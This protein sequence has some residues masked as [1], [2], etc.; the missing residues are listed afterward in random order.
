MFAGTRREALALKARDPGWLAF[1]DGAPAGFDLA[2]S[3]A[4][5][6][7]LDVRGRTIAQKT[8][9]GTVGAPAVA[10]A[11]W[12]CARASAAGATAEV[13][14][15]AGARTVTFVAT[16]DDGR[17]EEDPARAEY[18]TARV[19]APTAIPDPVWSGPP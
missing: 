16:G 13:L 8:T 19:G 2:D 17:A 3:P 9:A 4:R 12:C 10:D 6:R 18:I 5:L 11:G 7:P 14:R 15:R 1:Q